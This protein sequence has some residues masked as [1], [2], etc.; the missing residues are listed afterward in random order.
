MAEKL[1][2]A[3]RLGEEAPEINPESAFESLENQD[4][5]RMTE[6]YVEPV[7]IGSE[8]KKSVE[9]LLSKDAD[10]IKIEFALRWFNDPKNKE[11]MEKEGLPAED[12]KDSYKITFVLEHWKTKKEDEGKG[13]GIGEEMKGKEYEDLAVQADRI[14]S[15]RVGVA[16]KVPGMPFLMLNYLQE[17]TAKGKDEL[18]GLEKKAA[19]GDESAQIELSSKQNKLEELF[20]LKKGITEKAMHED[21]TGD[22][23]KKVAEGGFP[24]KEQFVEN[25]LDARA[26]KLEQKKNDEL[27][28]RA[29]Q[30]YLQLTPKQRGKY[31]SEIGGKLWISADDFHRKF[32]PKPHEIAMGSPEFEKLYMDANRKLFSQEVQKMATARNEVSGA[33]FYGMLEQGFRPWEENKKSFW[34]GKYTVA[35]RNG[36]KQISVEN[37]NKLAEN[38]GDNYSGDI[39]NKAQTEMENGWDKLHDEKV[40]DQVNLR[41]AV[42][43]ESP[44]DAEGGVEGAYKKARDRIVLEHIRKQVEKHPKTSEQVKILQKELNEGGKDININEVISGLLPDDEGE[45]KGRLGGLEQKW[46]DKIN[47][48]NFGKIRKYFSEDLGIDVPMDAIRNVITTVEKY[49]EIFNSKT[50]MLSIMFEVMGEANK[51]KKEEEVKMEVRKKAKSKTKAKTKSG[52]VKTTA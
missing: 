40:K 52:G 28:E 25:N 38:I 49:A 46:G 27:M 16:E 42:L 41:I 36:P 31:N 23:E 29:F 18:E 44:K 43:A 21:L 20:L 4:M 7:E 13:W 1:K 33:A 26:D 11:K 45:L 5:M 34:G 51:I 2:V 8:L 50:G 37:Y 22:A 6:K 19:Q 39:R 15:L 12:V 10:D 9:G 14:K 17:K 32:N 24:S 30:D 48:V 47:N 3:E 35:T